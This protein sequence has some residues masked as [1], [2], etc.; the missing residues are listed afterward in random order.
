MLKKN[1]CTQSAS[2][3][4]PTL[5]QLRQAAAQ[6]SFHLTDYLHRTWCCGQVCQSSVTSMSEGRDSLW[7]KSIQLPSITAWQPFFCPIWSAVLWSMSYLVFLIKN[8]EFIHWQTRFTP[9]SG[10]KYCTFKPQGL[11]YI[12]LFVVARYIINNVCHIF[13]FSLINISNVSHKFSLDGSPRLKYIW[14][15]V[16]PGSINE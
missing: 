15:P 10:L 7:F 14:Q 6:L 11:L 13:I 16:H 3:Y 8:A 12:H 2:K 9:F 5:P 1:A 4:L